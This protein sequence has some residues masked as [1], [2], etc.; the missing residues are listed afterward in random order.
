MADGNDPSA[1]GPAKQHLQGRWPFFRRQEDGG[2][3]G[4]L[5]GEGGGQW[6]KKV[7]QPPRR[8]RSRG[9]FEVCASLSLFHSLNLVGGGEDGLVDCLQE[10]VGGVTVPEC[11]VYTLDLTFIGRW[12]GANEVRS[13]SIRL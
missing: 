4:L 7:N 6:M 9:Q 8:G 2:G 13:H 12:A 10:R 5:E 3:E 1:S 11:S